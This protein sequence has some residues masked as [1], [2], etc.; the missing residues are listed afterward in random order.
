MKKGIM[1]LE[2]LIAFLLIVIGLF[3]MLSFFLPEGWLNRAAEPVKELGHWLIKDTEFKEPSTSFSQEVSDNFTALVNSFKDPGDG[4]CLLVYPELEAIDDRFSIS[5]EAQGNDMLIRVLDEQGAEYDGKVLPGKTPCIVAG[6]TA[7]GFYDNYLDGSSNNDINDFKAVNNI[8]ISGVHD[9]SVDGKSGYDLE[10]N[11]LSDGNKQISLLYNRDGK[12]ICFLTT[13][14]GFGGCNAKDIGLDD[15][16]IQILYDKN[17]AINLPLCKSAGPGLD[18]KEAAAKEE[19]RR[20]VDFIENKGNYNQLCKKSFEFN[21]KQL[22]GNYYIAYM[23]RSLILYFTDK[24]ID[25]IKVD[26]PSYVNTAIVVD[27]IQY[28]LDNPQDQNFFVDPNNIPQDYYAQEIRDKK[29][30]ELIWPIYINKLALV[31]K[32]GKW[33][34]LNGDLSFLD[35]DAPGAIPECS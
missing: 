12:H 17:K 19:F 14:D 25:E 3:A 23:G 26:M 29:G 11:G 4:P 2:K 28:W 5:I 27:N 9:M 22:A 6:D 32:D 13:F 1:P 24:R 33:A 34:L 10:D 7:D 35:T 8:V 20:F 15:N 31:H 30:A 21:A 16:C 18:A